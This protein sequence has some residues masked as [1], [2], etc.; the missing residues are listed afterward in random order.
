MLSFFVLRIYFIDIHPLSFALTTGIKLLSLQKPDWSCLKNLYGT[1][2]KRSAEIGDLLIESD[3]YRE[4]T[5][6]CLFIDSSRDIKVSV[7][8]IPGMF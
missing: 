7:R 3:F 4:R 2:V 1:L 8:T 6:I 5:G